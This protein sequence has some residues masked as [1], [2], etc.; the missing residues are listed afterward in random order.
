[1]NVENLANKYL[2]VNQ[3]S[4]RIYF[5]KIEITDFNAWLDFFKDPTS[6]DHW[7]E[8]RSEP[9]TDCSNWY[10]K[11]FNRYA[12]GRGG[13][14]ALIEKTTGKL[15]GHCGLLVQTVDG[16]LELEVGYSL[17]P[18]F[19]GRGYATEAAGKCRDFAFENKF[20][21]SLISIISLTNAPSANVALKNGMHPEKQ[22]VYNQNEVTI[23]RIYKDVWKAERSASYK[24]KS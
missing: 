21:E 23:F 11:Q 15:I 17:L 20:A 5:R 8:D 6:F 22:T 4:L 18:E 19:R 24:K 10:K 2:L 12:T 13:M 9:E 7:K 14:N 1:M 3:D 16:I